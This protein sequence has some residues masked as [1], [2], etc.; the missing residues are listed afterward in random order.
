VTIRPKSQQNLL[1][2][3]ERLSGLSLGVA[4]ALMSLAGASQAAEINLENGWSGSLN[5]TIS[6]GTSIRAQE[7]DSK[8]Y[9]QAAG[10]RVLGKTDGTGGSNTDSGNLN[11]GKGDAFS[12]LFKVTSDLSLSKGEAG[13]F[14]RVKAWY[15]HTLEKGNV[16]AGNLASN[17]VKNQPLSDSGF[18]PL[19]K[20][21]GIA[22]LDAYAYN[23]YDIDGKPL[24]VRLG[25]QVLNWGESL[26]VQGINVVNPIDLS[27][28]RKPGAE[29][30]DAFLP[31]PA[32]SMNLGLGEGR[33]LE[34]FYQFAFTPSNIDSCGTYF[35]V[36][37]TKLSDDPEGLCGRM[38]TSVTSF[39]DNSTAFALGGYI[40]LSKGE[41]SNDGQFGVNF[42]LPVESIDTELGFYYAN[43]SS[44]TPVVS[45]RTGSVALA[46]PVAPALNALAI[47]SALGLT[48]FTGFWSYPKDMEVFGVSAA[49]NVGGW[50]IGGELSVIPDYPAQINA[51]DLLNGALAGFGPMGQTATAATLRGPGNEV[52]GY[53]PLQKSQLQINGIKVLPR[54]MGSSQSVF[55]GE[56]AVQ[57]ADVGNTFTGLRYGR[58]FIFGAGAHED[59]TGNLC[60]NGSAL[61]PSVDGCKNDGFVTKNSWGYR[62]RLGL[63]YP[64]FM[65]T[66]ATFYPTISFSH[67]V[68]GYS[69]DNQFIEDRQTLGLSGRWNINKVHNVE[70][71]YVRYGDQAKYD[72]FR[73]RDF[74]SLVL[75]TTF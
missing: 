33:S 7:P 53:R 3:P 42:R 14:A 37:E 13:I 10:L 49:T 34:A 23:T 26:F 15:D 75:S 24:Q 21:S 8:L 39:G 70:V 68:K 16:R 60:L 30:K 35:G 4:A 74:Y 51:N 2:K 18:E 41:S 72:P 32:L 73:D 65:G 44:R 40:P 63:E 17:Y 27:A 1:C 69:V 36:V 25:N 9:S 5:T 56:L 46:A 64:G 11:Y 58:A 57:Q 55:V 62:M 31:I 19:Q 12:T 59:N 66:S 28:L 50:S 38:L 48:P 52:R 43:I 45:G 61:N 47:H 29:I 54:M 22:L 6:V 67:D 20:F 71:S